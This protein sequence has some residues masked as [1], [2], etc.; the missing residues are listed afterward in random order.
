MAVPKDSLSVRHRIRSTLILL[1]IIAVL[2]MANSSPVT[3][4]SLIGG[5]NNN[6][7][8]A[9]DDKDLNSVLESTEA[10]NTPVR[11]DKWRGLSKHQFQSDFSVAAKRTKEDFGP[12]TSTE[13]TFPGASSTWSTSV[14]TTLSASTVALESTSKE[15]PE[16]TI[17]EAVA[18]QTGIVNRETGVEP[19]EIV[20]EGEFK[21]GQRLFL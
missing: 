8:S 1:S 16:A 19:R 10:M 7:K 17:N 15:S 3:D 9:S 14:S 12:I 18:S 21:T 13:S 4:T 11:V 5:R 20:K 2:P 6:I